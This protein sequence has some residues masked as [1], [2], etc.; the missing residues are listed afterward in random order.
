MTININYKDTLFEWSNLTPIC[1]KPTVEMLHKLW[2][3]IK[4]NTK[5]VYSNLGGGAHGHLGLVL[6][7][8]QYTLIS[9]TNFFY[10]TH[11]GPLII[12]DGATAHVNSKMRIVHT[13]E[14]CLFREVTGVEESLVQQILGTV[15]EAYLVDIR[16]KIT[17]SI[18]DTVAGVLT[19]LQDNY[20]QLMPHDLLEQRHCQEDDLQPTRPDWK[21]VIQSQGNPQV[22][23]NYGDIIH[24]T[25]GGQYCLLHTPQDGQ[26]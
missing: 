23:W 17:N 1:G 22:F 21:S 7:E 11:L 4:A 18:N 20:V 6:T 13:E 9:S 14:V 16:N 12:P 3:E 10:P 2:N 26:V 15:E 25:V 24:A 8:A 5:Y 19:H